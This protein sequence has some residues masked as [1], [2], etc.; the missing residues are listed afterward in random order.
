MTTMTAPL[1]AQRSVR[2]HLYATYRL[3]FLIFAG[4][5]A[6]AW[7]LLT[8]LFV[9]N[10]DLAAADIA[11][12]WRW[13]TAPPAKYFLFTIALI[14]ASVQL[15]IYVAFGLTRRDVVLGSFRF[16]GPAVLF[17]ATFSLVLYGVIALVSWLLGSPLLADPAPA[18]GALAAALAMVGFVAWVVSGLLI[19]VGFVRF[20]AWGGIAFS[21]LG[22][23]PA[24]A[25]E[26]A[27]LRFGPLAILVV[28][29]AVLAG[30]WAVPVLARGVE[31]RKV[32]S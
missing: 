6:L 11:D 17:I 25:S 4:L 5:F 2:N 28:A 24:A 32:A 8:V 22:A 19:G 31:V 7:T 10:R 23:I 27:Y 3:P 14:I 21:A 26:L 18:D 9:L 16:F 29:V 13:G 20:G 15:R 30:G 1:L 12:I